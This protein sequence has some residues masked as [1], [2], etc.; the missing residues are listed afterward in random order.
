MVLQFTRFPVPVLSGF[1][2]GL[3]FRGLS[4]YKM[5]SKDDLENCVTVIQSPVNIRAIV[6]LIREWSVIQNGIET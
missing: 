4:Q 1:G 5:E 2:K 6:D 3:S